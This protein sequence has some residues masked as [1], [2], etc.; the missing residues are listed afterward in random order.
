MMGV[1]MLED[2]LRLWVLIHVHVA[3]EEGFDIALTRVPCPEEQINHEDRS[4]RVTKVQHEP[5][6][7]NGKARFGWAAF[8][9]AELLPAEPDPPRRKGVKRK[10][11]RRKNRG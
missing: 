3:D 1:F 4:Y 11:P 5:L 8:V 7:T 6:G 2:R 9:D 10:T